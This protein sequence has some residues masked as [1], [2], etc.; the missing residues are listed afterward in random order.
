[1]RPVKHIYKE[2]KFIFNVKKALTLPASDV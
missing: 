1:M 2:Y